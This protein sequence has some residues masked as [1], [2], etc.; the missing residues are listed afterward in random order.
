M[1]AVHH[2][3]APSSYGRMP[4]TVR[5][6]ALAGTIV[7]LPLDGRR[8]KEKAADGDMTVQEAFGQA[9][10]QISRQVS[11]EEESIAD[12]LQI[13]EAGL[14]FADNMGLDNYFRRQA[15]RTSGICFWG[16]FTHALTMPEVD[17]DTG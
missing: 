3:P 16:A 17:T 2:V 9:L 8:D 12:F 13:N 1:Y 5:R 10:E 14:T 7:R 15:A 11:R 4:Y 6:T